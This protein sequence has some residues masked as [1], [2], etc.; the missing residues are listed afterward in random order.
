MTN[1]IQITTTVIKL[2]EA[3][4]ITDNILNKKLAAC[5]QIIGPIKSI[6]WWKNKIENKKEW[7]CIIKTK[8]HFFKKIEKLIKDIHSYELPEITV[9][10]IING[11]K[12]YLK[13]IDNEVKNK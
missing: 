11:S 1:F 7:L 6:Y 10:P 9:I 5:A 8:K 13:W 4:K 2:E 12:E 3:I